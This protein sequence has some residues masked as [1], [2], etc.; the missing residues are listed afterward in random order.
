M[1]QASTSGPQQS[2]AGLSSLPRGLALSISRV[3]DGPDD[4][5]GQT[6]AASSSASTSTLRPDNA[7]AS[8]S[9]V[10]PSA[11][12]NTDPEPPASLTQ[13]LARQFESPYSLTSTSLD[14]TQAQQRAKLA[15]LDDEIDG[16]LERLSDEQSQAK[17]SSSSQI[18][19]SV[20]QLFDELDQIR[21]KAASS[22]TTVREITGDIRMLDTGKRNLVESMTL[23]RRLQMLGEL[24]RSASSPCFGT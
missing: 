24:H 11:S 15:L 12:T 16:M 19:L 13:K 14:R 23:L 2:T 3:L 21:E 1:A 22:E 8:T 18:Q 5:R 7:V 17:L 20:R 6:A 4:G 10:Q 9:S